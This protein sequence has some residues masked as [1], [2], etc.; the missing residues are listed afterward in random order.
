MS[1]IRRQVILTFAFL[2]LHASLTVFGATGQPDEE[3]VIE[4]QVR[5]DRAGFSPG[6]IDGRGGANTERA[7][8]AF[9]RERGLG[10]DASVGEVLSALRADAAST[11]VLLDHVVTAADAAGP[12]T[13]DIP[14]D[15][16]L[17]ADLPALGYTTL[18][19]KLGERF[20]ASPE[21]IARLNPGVELTEGATIRVPNVTPHPPLDPDGWTARAGDPGLDVVVSRSESALTVRRDGRA[22]LHAPVTTG[23]TRDPLPIGDWKVTTVSPYPTFHYDPDL[24][25]DADPAHAKATLPPGPNGPVGVVW[26]DLDKEHYGLHGTPEPS[27][28][29]HTS[30]HGCVRLTN[31]DAA[32]VA[33]LVGKGTPVRFV[34]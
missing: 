9:R 6:E 27:T 8:A 3:A 15:P 5:L 14:D 24:F 32:R 26:I 7:V 16:M 17:Q 28:I 11:P 10:P 13:A 30:S 1:E 21:L 20:H 4:L 2:L 23:S 19:E 34:E 22:I 18:A 33:V 31:W 29:G 25:W 12:F